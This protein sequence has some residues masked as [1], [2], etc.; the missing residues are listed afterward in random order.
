MAI[1]VAYVDLVMDAVVAS[2]ADVIRLDLSTDPVAELANAL[3]G[4]ADALRDASMVRTSIVADHRSAYPNI[5]RFQSLFDTVT[6]CY[7]NSISSN[8]IC[9]AEHHN[10]KS[11]RGASCCQRYCYCSSS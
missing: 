5:L 3:V 2:L 11:S 9:C 6:G 7:Y 4:R 10:V 1:D 8:G